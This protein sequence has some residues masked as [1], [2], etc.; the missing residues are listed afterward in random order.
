MYNQSLTAKRIFLNARVSTTAVCILVFLSFILSASRTRAQ[1]TTGYDAETARAFQLLQEGKFAEAQVAFEKLAATNSSDGRVM[2]GLGF[3]I[4]ATSKNIKDDEARRRARLRARNALLR[5]KELGFEDDLLEAGLAAVPPDG[6][7][8][9]KFSKN[10]EA[11]KAMHEGEAAFTRGDYDHAITAYE[12]ALKLDPQLYSAALFLGDMYFQNKQTDKAGEWYARAIAIDSDRETAYRYWS[13][14]LLK[15]N[16]MD[17]SRAKA[18]D[19]ILAEPYNPASYRALLQWAEVTKTSLN[20]P[21]IQPPNSVNT[22]DGQTTLSIDPKTLNSNDGTNHWLIYN[23]TRIAWSKGEFFKNYPDE[24]VYRHSL[25]EEAAALRMVAESA[26]NDLKSG[27]IK[28]LEQS[29]A[30]LVKLNEGGLLEPY[31]LFAH[32]DQ[33]IVRDYAAYRKDNRE[34]LRRY[35]L[36]VVVLK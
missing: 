35:W 26:A 34:K 27:K 19:A 17:E 28:A 22:E 16:K 5:A 14:V 6:S 31:I 24:K 25:K 21:K 13:D 2:F 4:L 32:P 12:R 30:V 7:E 29:L 15:N 9:L 1:D 10:P 8:A 18:I 33:G 11:D 23:L 3:S 20:H 36:E